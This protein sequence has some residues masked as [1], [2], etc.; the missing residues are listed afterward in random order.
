MVAPDDNTNPDPALENFA[1][2]ERDERPCNAQAK[3]PRQSNQQ[4]VFYSHLKPS[5]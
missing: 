1:W 3:S 4:N 5:K 2:M